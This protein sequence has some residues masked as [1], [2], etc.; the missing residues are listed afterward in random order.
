MQLLSHQV[1]IVTFG[2]VSRIASHVKHYN[3]TEMHDVAMV[4]IT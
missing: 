2:A 4:S 1:A 3:Y